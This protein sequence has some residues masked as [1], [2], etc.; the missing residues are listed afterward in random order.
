ML[1]EINGHLVNITFKTDNENG[2]IIRFH[3][4]NETD[5][6]TLSIF[7]ISQVAFGMC[8]SLANCNL[9]KQMTLKVR[10]V[11]RGEYLYIIQEAQSIPFA[12]DLEPMQ[13]KSA[14]LLN[15]ILP[16]LQ[17]KLNPYP[18]HSIYKPLNKGIQCGYFDAFKTVGKTPGPISEA[19]RELGGYSTTKR[20]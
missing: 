17:K 20:R 16:L 7:A 8:A 10:R 14:Y 1:S 6:I 4:V 11:E 13:R 3:F 2:E 19:E 9:H 18:Y 5:F 12:S 15:E